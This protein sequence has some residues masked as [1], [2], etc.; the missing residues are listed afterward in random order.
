MEPLLSADISL[1]EA[2][3]TLRSALPIY[4][5]R[6]KLL[7]IT[8]HLSCCS[9]AESCPALCHPMDCSRSGFPVLH[10]LLEFVQ[11]HVHWVSNAIHS[12][13]PLSHPSR[14]A[15]NLSQHQGFFLWVG[16]LHQVAKVLE[17]QLQHL[18]ISIFLSSHLKFI[19]EVDYRVTLKIPQFPNS[20]KRISAINNT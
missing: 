14:L 20:F 13:H 11:I 4:Q 17:L 8:W 15:L 9:V 19:S 18:G 5:Q 16:S 6:D 7:N 10:Y 1:G 3:E 2:E 12:A